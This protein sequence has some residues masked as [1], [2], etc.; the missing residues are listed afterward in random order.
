MIYHME[1]IKEF[2]P[3]A[4]NSPIARPVNMALGKNI[5]YK[6]TKCSEH[7]HIHSKGFTLI[8]RLYLCFDLLFDSYISHCELLKNCLSGVGNA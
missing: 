1:I 6:V 2:F 7:K 4:I 3:L 8:S 5:L